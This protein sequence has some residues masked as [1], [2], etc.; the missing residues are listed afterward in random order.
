[1]FSYKAKAIELGFTLVQD[2]ST[3]IVH[4]GNADQTKALC[5]S[6]FRVFSTESHF[7]DDF[8]CTRC[9]NKINKIVGE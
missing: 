8:G 1:M 2:C 9:I 7:A 5:N 3:N 4:L 6:R